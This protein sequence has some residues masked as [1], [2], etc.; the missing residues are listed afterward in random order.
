M[1]PVTLSLSPDLLIG[2]FLWELL[3]VYL[4]L[5]EKNSC[6]KLFPLTFVFPCPGIFLDLMHLKKHG[7]FDISLFYRDI[8]SVAEDEDLGVHF[9]ESSKLEDLLRKV[10]SRETKKRALSR[11]AL[12]LG[13]LPIVPAPKQ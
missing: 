7:G 6:R 5:T 1:I 4:N 8:I 13:H 10:L 2:L 3:K 12:S 9:E 11:W